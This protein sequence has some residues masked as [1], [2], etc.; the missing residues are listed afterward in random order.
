[1]ANRAGAENGYKAPPWIFTGRAFYQ[2][3]LV[4]SDV[5]RKYIPK[6]LKL[7]E[8]FGKPKGYG[9]G[10]WAEEEGLWDKPRMRLVVFPGLVWNPPTS[11]AW[12]SRVLV[13][14]HTAKDHGL[15]EVGLPSRLAE[16]TKKSILRNEPVE[17]GLRPWWRPKKSQTPAKLKKM[18][19]A[20]DGT[21]VNVNEA[22]S[23][24]R[25]PLLRFLL[26]PKLLM[27][28]EKGVKAKRT[29]LSLP[30]FSGRTEMQPDLLKYSCKM[31]CRLMSMFPSP[32]KLL[33]HAANKADRGGEGTSNQ[34]PDDMQDLV[35]IVGGK[36]LLSIS[37]HEMTMTVQAPKRVTKPLRQ[38]EKWRAPNFASGK[39]WGGQSQ[40]PA[41]A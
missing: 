9:G 21:L 35:A 28:S 25:K 33:S 22:E 40:V 10:S 3:H 4:K 5:A 37:F 16:I 20:E 8:A 30:S 12:A 13:T 29:T 11:C 17:E 36:R 32:V 39:K 1:M 23:G 7:V 2:M 38:G 27:L 19:A 15:K 31:D 14:S 18:P 6:E 41:P 24:Q 26:P 34:M